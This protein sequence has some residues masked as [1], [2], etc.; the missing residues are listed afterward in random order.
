M[1]IHFIKQFKTKQISLYCRLNLNSAS[2]FS[3][4]LSFYLFSHR[5]ALPLP[6]IFAC[7]KLFLFKVL[8]AL[9]DWRAGDD[10]AYF[11]FHFK[12]FSHPV[13]FHFQGSKLKKEN[14]MKGKESN[15]L[16]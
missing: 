11:D 15:Y 14:L 9:N 6:R 5:L 7:K 3:V 12:L 16:H 2:I 10:S 1:L 13:D 8:G 4:Y